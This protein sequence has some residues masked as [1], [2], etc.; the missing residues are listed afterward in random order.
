MARTTL[1]QKLDSAILAIRDLNTK[2]VEL[3][4]ENAK[5]RAE[6]AAIK[7][8]TPAPELP[9]ASIE[10]PKHVERETES[11]EPVSEFKAL[12]NRAK[13][14]TSVTGASHFVRS[15]KVYRGYGK[16]AVAIV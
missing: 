3:G 14:L 2:C 13:R 10:A 15:G 16:D 5:L 7:N 4:S 6:L 9:N 11:E 12:W 1:T 8:P